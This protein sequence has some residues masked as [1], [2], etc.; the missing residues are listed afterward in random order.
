MSSGN[1]HGSLNFNIPLPAFL[2]S[3]TTRN[4]LLA[5]LF[6]IILVFSVVTRFNFI[7]VLVILLLTFIILM[8]GHASN[9]N[10]FE[11]SLP[12]TSYPNPPHLGLDGVS[13]QNSM[14]M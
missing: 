13:L 2:F 7:T 12:S 11:G 5:L 10:N 1:H 4:V 9:G 14:V 8:L 3:R 6:A